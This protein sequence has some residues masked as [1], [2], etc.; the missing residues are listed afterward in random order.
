MGKKK[1]DDIQSPKAKK[2]AFICGFLGLIIYCG[3][4]VSLRGKV[5]KQPEF[6]SKSGVFKMVDKLPLFLQ[7]LVKP[8][9]EA[10]DLEGQLLHATDKKRMEILYKLSA[11]P[12]KISQEEAY[13]MIWQEYPDDHETLLALI[14]L[15]QNGWIDSPIES[16]IAYTDR[17][18]IVVPKPK[19][20]KQGEPAERIPTEAEMRADIWASGWGALSNLTK[21]R[22]LPYL[23][24]LARREIV[25]SGLTEAYKEL[26]GH[27]AL[28]DKQELYNQVEELLATC[29]VL[30]EQEMIDQG[31]LPQ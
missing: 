14:G 10:A 27:A 17:V 1:P 19:K 9:V 16:L 13:R 7:T 23:M 31:M 11:L 4:E 8:R 6:D 28:E 29:T 24:E 2:I 3:A 26:Q 25:H 30:Q 15:V 5:Y 22:R 21:E 12:S 20:P 18:K